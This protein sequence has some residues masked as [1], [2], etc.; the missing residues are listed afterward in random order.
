MARPSPTWARMRGDLLVD[1]RG[2]RPRGRQRRPAR[3]GTAAARPSRRASGRPRDGTARRRSAG[4]RP[5]GR[6]PARSSV[7][8]VATKPSGTS[9]MA[10]KWLIHTSW[11]SGASSGSSS[12]SAVRRSLARPYSPRIPRPTVAAELLGD[13][14]GAVADAEHRDAEV[15]DGRVERSAHRRRGRSWDR[16]TGSA[17]RGRRSATSA[18]V[19]RWG[20]ISEYT[21]S[22]RTRRAISWAYWAPKSTTRTACSCSLQGTDRRQRW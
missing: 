6:R 9:V 1:H 7:A 22:S 4:R 18:A 14:L 20:T 21:A 15:V 8:A 2:H 16:R 11:T 10:S 17:R 19:M 3:A 13:Q 12:E 5:P